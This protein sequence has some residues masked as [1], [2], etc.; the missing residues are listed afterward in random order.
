MLTLSVI[1]VEDG[2]IIAAAPSGERFRLPVDADLR[3]R[4]QEEPP[5]PV[6]PR[7][8]PREIQ[9]H[10][11][12]GLSA[13]Q[14]AALTGAPVAYIERFVGPVIAEREYITETARAVRLPPETEGARAK[15]FG[16]VM[17]ERLAALAAT[18]VRWTSTRETNGWI[19]ALTFT[20]DDIE[21]D[22]RWRFDAKR[23]Q[24]TP[25]NVE[26]ATLSQQGTPAALTPRLRAIEPTVP[27]TVVAPSG[28]AD[29]PEP[30]APPAPDTS[31]FDSA[32]FA[33]PDLRTP[34]ERAA[35]VPAPKRSNR[36]APTRLIPE[37][38]ADPRFGEPQTEDREPAQQDR[39]PRHTGPTTDQLASLSRRRGEREPSI[40]TASLPV[41]RA[42]SVIDTDDEDEDDPFARRPAKERD[43][44]APVTRG[45]F[46]ERL[47]E[48]QEQV[49]EPAP[50][51]APRTEAPMKRPR[52]RSGTRGSVPRQMDE[53]GPVEGAPSS[54]PRRGRTTMPSWD[55][56][57]FGRDED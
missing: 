14:V 42:M 12:A 8:S 3:A 35:E 44:P 7:L 55:E 54:R 19:V 26:A 53:S 47:P 36:S 17:A 46:P 29:V 43:T 15:T 52:S 28:A 49:E 2:A 30:V 11:R 45:R 1:G 39:R 16:A 18:G 41:T 25:E 22:A 4:L 33:F 40:D 50:K 10:V 48:P 5:A 31:R 20:A 6:G 27:I 21:H 57:V 9:S 13:Q 23:M 37:P 51:P 34:E 56:I 38:V 32:I 24:L